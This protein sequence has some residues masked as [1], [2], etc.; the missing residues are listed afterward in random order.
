MRERRLG[1]KR[2]R[3]VPA[4]A[5]VLLL[6]GLALLVSACA[7]PVGIKPVDIQ[8]AYRIQTE[9]AL[10]AKQPSEPSKTVLRRLGLMDRF[11]EDPVAVLGKLHGGLQPTGDDDRLFA[12]A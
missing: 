2:R 8:T 1:T 11:D 4:P 6:A 3:L 9:S 5:W 10:S 7:T 12:L